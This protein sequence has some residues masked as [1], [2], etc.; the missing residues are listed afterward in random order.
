MQS[1]LFPRL[2]IYLSPYLK[3][4]MLQRSVSRG[5]GIFQAAVDGKDANSTH[6]YLAQTIEEV[7]KVAK[8]M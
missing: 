8:Y 2:N 4:Y 6:M 3:Q 1:N 7:R 5:V